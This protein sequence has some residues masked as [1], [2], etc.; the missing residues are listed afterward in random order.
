MESKILNIKKFAL[1]NHVPI[2]RNKTLEY[3]LEA[4]REDG[5]ES[6]LEI[7][8]AIGYSGALMLNSNKNATLT[9]IEKNEKSFE[10]AKENFKDLG[11]E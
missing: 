1:D 3:L 9:T 2:V 8:T 5:I 4:V 10:I 7:G 11:V 6:V